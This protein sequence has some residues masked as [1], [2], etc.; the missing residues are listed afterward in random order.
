MK[1]LSSLFLS[2]CTISLMLSFTFISCNNAKELTSFDVVYNF[3][4]VYFTYSQN[5]LKSTQVILYT[6]KLTINFDSIL[7]ANHIP[8]G[9][10]SSAYLSKLAMIIT[11]PPQATFN[12]LASVNVYGSSDSTFQQPILLGA[13]TVNDPS[14]KNINLVLNNVD[15]KPIL[16]KYSYFVEVSAT[17]SGQAPAASSINMYLVSQI[18]LHIEP[19]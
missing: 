12:W 17:P 5:D 7:G 8:S 10:I 11:A 4:N 3:P 15:L 2:L 1:G 13:D 14:A 19:L 16:Y 6:G 18:K 9:I